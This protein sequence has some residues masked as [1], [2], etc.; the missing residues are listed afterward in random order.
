MRK[1]SAIA[2]GMCLFAA[3]SKEEE[4]IS[5]IDKFYETVTGKWQVVYQGQFNSTDSTR[6]TIAGTPADF[7]EFRKT[8]TVYSQTVLPVPSPA[9][10]SILNVRR[11]LVN[12]DTI[13]NRSETDGILQLY[14]RAPLTDTSY[15]E[16]WVE[17]KKAP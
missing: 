3:C 8:D 9:L 17:L 6:D 4:G 14:T 7:M 11:F 13:Y 1:L 2:T 5:G 16:W 15:T 12:G 10:Y